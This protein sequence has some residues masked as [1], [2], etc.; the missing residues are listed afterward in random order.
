LAGTWQGVSQPAIRA[1]IEL[2]QR[3]ELTM[4]QLAEGMGISKGW[5]SRV[6]EELETAA[7]VERAGDPADRRVVRVRLAASAREAVGVAYRWRMEPIERALAGLDP[8]QR[9]AVR[10]FLARLIDELT[11]AD[12]AG[13]PAPDRKPTR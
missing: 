10:T 8:V 11:A 1:A 7:I 12:A 6:V 5:A 3:G 4:G 9:R 13:E 2:H